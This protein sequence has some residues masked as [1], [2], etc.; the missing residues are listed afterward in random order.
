[1]IAGPRIKTDAGPA[2][3]AVGNLLGTGSPTSP[4]PTAAP[5]TSR[6]SPGVGDGFFNDHRG[7]EDLPGR[8]GPQRAVPGRLQRPGHRHRGAERRVEL[9]LADRPDRAVSQTIDAGGREPTSRVRGRLH[10]QRLHRPGGGRQRRRPV[11][12]VHRRRRRPEPEPDDHQRRRCPSPTWLSFAGV[13]DGV[14]SFYASTAG[15]EA[16]T[17]LAF[18]LNPEAAPAGS[19]YGPGS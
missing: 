16:A 13:T 14:L 2:A 19:G 11:G 3:V 18:N 9:D 1:M 17:L 12:A 6:S 15:R 7:G 10:R 8:P 5:T 4:W